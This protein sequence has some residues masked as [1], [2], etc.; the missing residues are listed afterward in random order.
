HT[1]RLRAALQAVPFT[2]DAVYQMLGDEAHRALLRNQTVP[3]RRRTTDQSPLATLTR[4]FSLQLPVPR[5]HADRAPGALVEPLHAAG[6]L[7]ASA[8]EVRALLDIRPYGDAPGPDHP[9]HDWWVVCDLTPGLDG[10]P[11]RADPD[12]VLGISEASGS[13]AQLTI[14]H[15]VGTALD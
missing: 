12:H 3:A 15:P 14:H 13:L 8:G 1:D 10:V 5:A 9:G 7:Q 4:L 2:V 11:F 6:L